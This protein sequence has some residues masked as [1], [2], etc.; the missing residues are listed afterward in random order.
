MRV[1]FFIL[2]IIF[3]SLLPEIMSGSGN[4]SGTGLLPDNSHVVLMHPTV[5]NIKTWLFLVSEGIIPVDP[6]LSILGVYSDHGAYD[7]S[8]SYD[9]IEAENTGNIKLLGVEAA[10]DP[11][12]LYS[13]NLNSEVFKEIFRIAR[14]IIFFGGPDIPPSTYGREMS[15]LTVV[16][17][18]HRH[19]LELSFLFHLLGGFQDDGFIPLLEKRPELPVLGICLGMQT[20]NVATGGTMIQDIPFYIYGKTTVE[21]VTAMEPDMQHRNYYSAYRTHPEIGARSFHRI[22]IEEGSLMETIAGNSSVMPHVLSSHHQALDQTG[23]GFRITARSTD[24]KVPEA[25]EHLRY[26]NVTG[27]QFHPEVSTLFMGDSR[28][29]LIPGEEPAG[30]FPELYPGPEGQDFHM[31]FWKH[32]GGLLAR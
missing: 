26:P 24:G 5:A 27:I 14:G 16:T 23:K 7:Y 20:M 32:F 15:L 28:I 1:R 4:H 25:I 11:V 9:F 21:Q 18:P 2:F 29:T 17:D 3:Q 6:E 19:Y 8:Q 12:S 31:N 13:E 10:T 30:S 22:M